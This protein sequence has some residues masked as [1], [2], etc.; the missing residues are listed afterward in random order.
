LQNNVFVLQKGVKSDIMLTI[1][2]KKLEIEPKLLSRI[3][4]A[5]QF[6]TKDKPIIVHGSLRV[7]DK[8]NLA[9]IEP[10]K[11][12]VNNS[13]YLFFN[14][15]DYFYKNDLTTKIPLKNLEEYIRNH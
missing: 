3:K 8:T 11:V 14:G 15:I 7:I 1:T 5:C 6:G 10:H 4:W 12:F 2:K 9:Y 13:I